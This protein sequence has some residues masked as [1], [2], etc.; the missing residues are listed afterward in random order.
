MLS[1]TKIICH[2]PPSCNDLNK[3][4]CVFLSKTKILF[5]KWVHSSNIS[6]VILYSIII[7]LTV[8]VVKVN[9]DLNHVSNTFL[10]SAN[11]II[12]STQIL[13]CPSTWSKCRCMLLHLGSHFIV[14]ASFCSKRLVVL[15]SCNISQLV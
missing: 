11:F 14:N 1:L 3:S 10:F 9:F 5:V 15:Y 13:F 4:N 6:M 2:I 12:F 8:F 7:T